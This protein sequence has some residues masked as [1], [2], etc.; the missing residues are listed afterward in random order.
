MDTEFFTKIFMSLIREDFFDG[1]V[2]KMVI[3]FR[4]RAMIIA[5]VIAVFSTLYILFERFML[6]MAKEEKP[7]LPNIFQ[8]IFLIAGIWIYSFSFP[9]INYGIDWFNSG[10]K[11]SDIQKQ[12]LAQESKEN[13]EAAL[14]SERNLEYQSML[15]AS[16]DSTLSPKIREYAK[17]K[18]AELDNDIEDEKNGNGFWAFVKKGFKNVV[19]Y[20][21]PLSRVS[22]GTSTI[23][24]LL[25]HIIRVAM[26]MFSEF[27]FKF[28]LIVGVITLATSTLGIWRGMFRMWFSA[29]ILT[30]G[31]QAVFNIL[32]HMMFAYFNAKY[33]NYG[34]NFV[35]DII[36]NLVVI[37]LFLCPFILGRHFIANANT[38]L[39][40][41]AGKGIMLGAIALSAGSGAV[42]SAF[43]ASSEVL[44]A[45]NRSTSFLRNT[46]REASKEN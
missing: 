42:L 34:L 2:E 13:L 4:A 8:M 39:Q 19:Y 9:L 21:S 12:Q 14:V 27:V 10:F 36:M 37:V 29:T 44:G 28:M 24:M 33:Q 32:D 11:Q 1:V 46:A 16:Q 35:A 30:G 15:D 22:W 43:G 38:G 45:V 5:V 6:R 41:I 23:C 7:I 31:I 40:N 26:L 20:L 17:M 3:H 25:S 18:L